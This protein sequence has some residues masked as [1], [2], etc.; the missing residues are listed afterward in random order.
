MSLPIRERI[1][2]EL[3]RRTRARR[4]LE[5]YDERDLPLTVLQEGDDSA[6]EGLYG[7]TQVATQVLVARAVNMTGVKG[8]DW[9]AELNTALAN[10][11]K[12]I[13]KG[14]NGIEGLKFE[15]NYVSGGI[16][17]PTDASK[18]SGVAVTVNVRYAFVYGN[19]YS[20]DADSGYVDVEPEEPEEPAPEPED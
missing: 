8:D 9:H 18:G 4:R 13:F 5:S 2:R 6:V 15:L 11:I 20:Q 19:P 14:G 12:E 1:L 17:L 3:V 7:M 10:L 16:G